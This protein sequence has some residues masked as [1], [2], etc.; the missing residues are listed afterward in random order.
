MIRH[1]GTS[2]QKALNR[3]IY[4]LEYEKAKANA[5]GNIRLANRIKLRIKTIRRKLAKIAYG[6]A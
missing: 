1:E 4:E 6:K 5:T 3:R 2:E